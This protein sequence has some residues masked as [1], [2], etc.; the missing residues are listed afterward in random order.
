MGWVVNA[1]T[2][3]CTPGKKSRYPVY[4]RLG[5]LQDR[6]ERVWISSSPPGFDPRTVQTVSYR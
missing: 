5:E 3:C 4:R 2:G 6:Y 1:M